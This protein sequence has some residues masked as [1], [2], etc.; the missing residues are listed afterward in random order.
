M[1]TF[2]Q[3]LEMDIFARAEALEEMSQE[4]RIAMV[5]DRKP[6]PVPKLVEAMA[7]TNSKYLA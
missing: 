4:E 5:G 7:R 3:L 6:Q 1:Y 2:E